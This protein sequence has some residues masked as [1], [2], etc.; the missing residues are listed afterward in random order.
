ML[1]DLTLPSY[2]SHKKQPGS[3]G[4]FLAC[5]VFAIL[6]VL[7]LVPPI[8]ASAGGPD[9][10][11]AS[12]SSQAISYTHADPSTSDTLASAQATEEAPLCLAV[13]YGQPFQW[14][15][16]NGGIAGQ[17]AEIVSDGTGEVVLLCQ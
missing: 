12:T 9:T 15:W 2:W 10:A 7:L 4:A 11:V 14:S 1:G 8:V 13:A 17:R 3:T 5:L 16:L 6:L